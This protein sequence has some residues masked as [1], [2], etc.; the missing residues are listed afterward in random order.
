MA[1]GPPTLIRLVADFLTDSKLSVIQ[2]LLRVVLSA[3]R[4]GFHRMPTDSLL[5]G[6][7]FLISL[8]WPDA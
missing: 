2:R 3:L 8:L 5:P 6:F 7:S 1:P 4:Q